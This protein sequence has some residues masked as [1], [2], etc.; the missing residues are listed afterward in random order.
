M[1]DRDAVEALVFRAR[2][3]IAAARTTVAQAEV[4]TE[5]SRLAND[6]YALIRRCAWCGRLALGRWTPADEAPAFLTLRAESKATHGICPDCLRRIEQQ[7]ESIV[8]LS[9]VSSS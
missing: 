7:L 5:A 4:L 3:A 8:P 9:D 1:D 2:S 6:R